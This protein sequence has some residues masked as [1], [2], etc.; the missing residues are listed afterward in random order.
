VNAALKHLA[1]GVLVRSGVERLARRT[2]RGRTL[3]LGY[4]NVLPH[5]EPISGDK[6]LHLPQKDFS[7][8]LD[9]IAQ[10]H[11]VV[12]IES[13]GRD[14]PLTTRPRVVITFDDAYM[15]A[16]T[17]GVEELTKRGM[18]ATVFVAP[19]LI[20][21]VSW[22]DTLAERANG[23]VSG[24]TRRQ[25]LETLGGNADAVLRWAS[26]TFAT[27]GSSRSLPRIGTMTQLA[28]AAAQPGITLGSHSWSHPNLCALS[29]ADLEAELSRSDQWLRSRF[30]CV[31]PWLSYPYGL[32]NESVKRAAAAAR[33]LGAL[34]IDGGWLEPSL[35]LPSYAVPRLNIPSGLSLD[36]FRL[37]LAGF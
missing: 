14:S 21:S 35:S 20:D 4:H 6:N 27:P 12:P 13:I 8:Q 19:A 23:T 5:G 33:Y 25:V 36:G 9:V 3:V 31:V 32:Y 2:R 24:D 34:R 7:R 11:D 30:S 37:R 17:G 26:S 18:P 10:T 16:L 29:E 28:R 22:W 15:G 1:E